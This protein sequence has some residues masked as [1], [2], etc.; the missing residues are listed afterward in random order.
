M[1]NTTHS[2]IALAHI[3][4]WIYGEGEGTY[5]ARI[6]KDALLSLAGREQM[7]LSSLQT[8]DTTRRTWLAE[9]IF[10]LHHIT[11]VELLSAAGVSENVELDAK[12][13]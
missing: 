2:H 3:H 1:Q 13:R 11:T 9:V 10:G 12:L 4:I 7:R 5:S 6:L 8:L